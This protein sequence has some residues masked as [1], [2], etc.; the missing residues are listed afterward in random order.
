[1]LQGGQTLYAQSHSF[2]SRIRTSGRKTARY[3]RAPGQI[4]RARV[5]TGG[6]ARKLLGV[7]RV[8]ALPDAPRGPLGPRVGRASPGRPPTPGLQGLALWPG[9]AAHRRPGPVTVGRPA[10]GPALAVPGCGRTPPHLGP[11]A[12]GPP[13]RGDRNLSCPLAGEPLGVASRGQGLAWGA[14]TP[15]ADRWRPGQTLAPPRLR[16]LDSW[17]LAAPQDFSAPRF[18]RGLDICHR[19]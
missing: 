8:P 14:D 4:E 15:P 10:P 1:M 3:T 12:P 9:H 16:P 2:T 7:P 17:S 18:R 13:W 11:P 5:W 6:H 19:S